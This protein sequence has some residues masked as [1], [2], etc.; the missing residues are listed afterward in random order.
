MF[1]YVDGLPQLIEKIRIASYDND[2][3]LSSLSFDITYAASSPI[4]ILI[5]I[6]GEV[7]LISCYDGYQLGASGSFMDYVEATVN[8]KPLI[9]R[10]GLRM[11]SNL[12]SVA[13][14]SSVIRRCQ[15]SNMIAPSSSMMSILANLYKDYSFVIGMLE[16]CME[17][18][19]MTVRIVYKPFEI[20]IGGDKKRFIPI[21]TNLEGVQITSG[22]LSLPDR[23]IFS[24]LPVQVY[25]EVA[26]NMIIAGKRPNVIGPTLYNDNPIFLSAASF[27]TPRMFGDVFYPARLG[28]TS[29]PFVTADH[30]NVPVVNGKINIG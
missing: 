20:T 14:W 27:G 30:L 22:H 23:K 10:V 28:S 8:E 12:S 19:T 26:G 1:F 11:I 15:A 4:G 13:E 5:P 25:R 16:P 24:N 18:T 2:N 7:T 6:A 17:G 29:S 21:A 9:S 3:E